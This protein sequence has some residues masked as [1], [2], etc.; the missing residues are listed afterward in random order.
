MLL[1][2][3]IFW[4]FGVGKRDVEELWGNRGCKD[5]VDVLAVVKLCTDPIDSPEL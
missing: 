5:P 2:V 4:G 1:E 3:W